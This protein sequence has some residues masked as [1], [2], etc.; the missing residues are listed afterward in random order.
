MND[1]S[2]LRFGLDEKVTK[3]ER[4]IDWLSGWLA[5]FKSLIVPGEP[6]KPTK[7]P[8]WPDVATLKLPLPPAAG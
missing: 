6:S 5:K 1:R 2:N 8:V 7:A 3:L 4:R